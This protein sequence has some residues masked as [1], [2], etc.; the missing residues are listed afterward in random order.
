V[1][2]WPQGV[3]EAVD[4]VPLQMSPLVRQ[5]R[6]VPVLPPLPPVPVAGAALQQDKP[7]LVPQVEQIPPLPVHLV[8]GAVHALAVPVPAA[9]QDWPG[10]PQL[11]QLPF[12][13][14]PG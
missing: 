12:A 3:Q 10:P 5:T 1:A 6:L 8:P 2:G 7:A 13:Q 9:Q 14:T 4:E 11:P